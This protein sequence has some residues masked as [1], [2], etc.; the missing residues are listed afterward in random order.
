MEQNTVQLMIEIQYREAKPIIKNLL[1]AYC[2]GFYIPFI[3]VCFLIN[4]DFDMSK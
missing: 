2:L 4:Y 1:I 3:Y